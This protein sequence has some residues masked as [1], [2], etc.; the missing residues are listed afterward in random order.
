MPVLE[1]RS[2]L[3]SF[4]RQAGLVVGSYEGRGYGP[5]VR[6][7][8]NNSIMYAPPWAAR[9][10][11]RLRETAHRWQVNS[12]MMPSKMV[13]AVP[14]NMVGNRSVFELCDYILELSIDDRIDRG[15][16]D[17]IYRTGERVAQGRSV[18]GQAC[19]T[20][21]LPID[22]HSP[23]HVGLSLTKAADVL[24]SMMTSIA[25]YMKSV[26]GLSKSP[27]GDVPSCKYR[28][29]NLWVL[30]NV[31][32]IKTPYYEGM[33]TWTHFRRSLRVMRMW[34]N[35]ILASV[36]LLGPTDFAGV[37]ILQ[38]L[39]EFWMDDPNA[40]G[41]WCK[42]AR[43]YLIASL[44][45]D[46]ILG[47]TA[48]ARLSK[49]YDIHKRHQMKSIVSLI[50][51][52]VRDINARVSLSHIYK[53]V[54]HPDC[55]I[56]ECFE[57]TF[58]VRSP[59]IPDLNAIPHV[60]G[61]MRRSIWRAMRQNSHP[62]RIHSGD[63]FLVSESQKTAPD[64]KA[65][66]AIPPS[67]WTSARFTKSPVAEGYMD[68]DVRPVDKAHTRDI[69]I[70]ELVS[71]CN[72]DKGYLTGEAKQKN[73]PQPRENDLIAALRD[74]IRPNSNA[75][76]RAFQK[77]IQKHQAFEEASG[78]SYPE[79]ILSKDLEEFLYNHPE[80]SH[81]VTTE[82]KFGETHKR[83]TRM[84]YVAT[85]KVKLYLSLAERLTKNITKHQIGNSIVS[86][87][88]HRR[89]SL[90][91]MARASV[92]QGDDM[93]SLFISFDMSEFSKKFPMQLVRSFGTIL[94]ELAGDDTL[95][96]LDLA[97]RAAVVAHSSRGL[98]SA[99]AG[100][101]G[102]FEGFLNFIW[103]SIHIA[104]M[105]VALMQAGLSGVVMAYS[106]DGLLY[107]QVSCEDN[108]LNERVTRAVE[109]IQSTY[110]KLGLVFHIHKTLVA[111]T[112]F[113]YLGEIASEG[114]FIPMWVKSLASLG[115]SEDT[116][117]LRPCGAQMSALQGQGASCVEAGLSGRFVE[118]MMFFE[119][120]L[121]M[122]RMVKGIE[123]V[124][125]IAMIISPPSA[126]GFGLRS[127]YSM[128]I[129]SEEQSL[130]VFLAELSFLERTMPAVARTVCN[131]ISSNILRGKR[132]LKKYCMGA[133]LPT[134]MPDTS[135]VS[136][137]ASAAD[138]IA[139]NMGRRRPKNPL[140]STMLNK[141]FHV[142]LKSSG[143]TPRLLSSI[144]SVAPQ[145][146]SYLREQDIT[147]G[148]GAAKLLDKE[149]L[150]HLQ[151]EDSRRVRRAYS[152]WRD[153]SITGGS[154][155]VLMLLRKLEASLK[156]CGLAKP[157]PSILAYAGY[158]TLKGHPG[159]TMRMDRGGEE[160]YRP[161][162]GSVK[163][164][165][166]TSVAY[167]EP[168]R[169]HAPHRSHVK[170]RSEQA[171]DNETPWKILAVYQSACR[172]GS[173]GG[174]VVRCISAALGYD[175]PLIPPDRR[176]NLDRVRA[177][178]TSKSSVFKNI[179][180][181][182]L[183]LSTAMPNRIMENVIRESRGQDMTTPVALSEYLLSLENCLSGILW[184]PPVPG[185]S[186]IHVHFKDG[187]HKSLEPPDPVM[188]EENLHFLNVAQLQPQVI[189]KF[190]QS[191]EADRSLISNAAEILTMGQ[192]G[193]KHR[194]AFGRALANKI[195]KKICSVI[196]MDNEFESLRIFSYRTDIEPLNKAIHGWA[197][198]NAAR[199]YWKRVQR[200]YDN[201][202]AP[203][204]VGK[205]Y[206]Y[207][208]PHA[209]YR[210]AE[211]FYG[212]L[213]ENSSS[214][215]DWVTSHESRV[216]L[217]TEKYTLHC[218]DMA[219]VDSLLKAMGRPICVMSR[220]GN[221]F[222]TQPIITQVR[223]VLSE[224][225]V[226][227]YKLA[228]NA[229]GNEIW[230]QRVRRMGGKLGIGYHRGASIDSVLNALVI[231]KVSLRKS[232]H[233]RQ[234]YNRTTF[235]INY[236]KMR[237][238][239][240]DMYFK[241]MSPDE[242]ESRKDFRSRVRPIVEKAVL[243]ECDL[244][245]I[246]K[247]IALTREPSRKGY[248]HRNLLDLPL[249]H[250]LV[251]RVVT[252][253]L[254]VRRMP[255]GVNMDMIWQ[256]AIQFQ[257]FC[258]NVIMT[259]VSERVKVYP[260]DLSTILSPSSGSPE[261]LAGA[262][263]FVPP[264]KEAFYG[265]II[266]QHAVNANY[267]WLTI[268][269]AHIGKVRTLG[270][271]PRVVVEDDIPN[272]LTPLLVEQDECTRSG[273]S[274]MLR[275]QK[276]RRK[277]MIVLARSYPTPK[278]A[279]DAFSRLHNSGC[280]SASLLYRAIYR[281]Y[282]LLGAIYYG[283]YVDAADEYLE[284]YVFG[285][286]FDLMPVAA[287][288]ATLSDKRCEYLVQSDVHRHALSIAISVGHLCGGKKVR[289]VARSGNL[290]MSVLG[291]DKLSL[292]GAPRVLKGELLITAASELCQGGGTKAQHMWAYCLFEAGLRQLGY[293]FARRRFAELVGIFS[294]RFQSRF[295]MMVR[296][297]VMASATG[298]TSFLRMNPVLRG[299]GDD[300]STFLYEIPPMGDSN[301]LLEVKPNLISVST[302][303]LTLASIQRWRSTISDLVDRQQE[304]DIWDVMQSVSID[305]EE[306]SYA[307]PEGE[308]SDL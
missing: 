132:A 169:A 171:V 159:I 113:E 12:K 260:V 155:T 259:V 142:L 264:V 188:I 117:D 101:G 250:S 272:Q 226:D 82:P 297:G 197:V 72:M 235:C 26:A 255:H 174:S 32:M 153:A 298:I 287:S 80:A 61:V 214:L 38:G 256:D 178:F 70:Q 76:R 53:Y 21:L 175:L 2:S 24:S 181:L 23:M 81:L 77:L 183:A 223:N 45:P 89:S 34:R 192:A 191:V 277:N 268:I 258:H 249:P 143:V 129:V 74:N 176:A 295:L 236:T 93:A 253:L 86:S 14:T 144:V 237:V 194:E 109:S 139:E 199:I 300:D 20:T 292:A 156:S 78:V 130:S 269:C 186:F 28:G 43:N 110:K 274:V 187:F 44:A 180:S 161:G 108:K 216:E 125:C 92:G 31:V 217:T 150:V 212:I 305:D 39:R 9:L 120:Y 52:H 54:P 97:F 22:Q 290:R 140:T 302:Q 57:S 278:H 114:R 222:P 306:R 245:K 219:H 79:E 276:G 7:R 151:G 279:V 270:C 224:T 67:R 208:A 215:P 40:V 209:K 173:S 201:L 18:P 107:A 25:K 234:M 307:L 275:W 29:L 5:K 133:L 293:D 65:M 8:I 13:A 1:L 124:A 213:V 4:L 168:R 84:F 145:M 286:Y 103:T 41:E 299:I 105:E 167:I 55:P 137:M 246:R 98:K 195:A 119:S 205:S 157:A 99:F 33:M 304:V 198:L 189:R 184:K 48:A 71:P 60:E 206:G 106:D 58:P 104:V 56:D 138:L 11:L 190:Y 30:G 59:N 126:G 112:T 152:Y 228:R 244:R 17:E 102:G 10:Y 266:P 147:R 301:M 204:S 177:M 87:S 95:G 96:R 66:S 88:R 232:S 243:K 62:P 69:D 221:Y 47:D 265:K 289:E 288:I 211:N 91:S 118:P 261:T 85:L 283:S 271:L 303:R 146:I 136:T 248:D 121:R 6:K 83:V 122:R 149:D 75:C 196:C 49:A 241:G 185:F 115:V 294:P 281:D 267:D 252:A 210:T 282:V 238:I 218:H 42:A 251:S 202:A 296:R 135:G 111:T 308:W 164:R 128:S 163:P 3:L 127:S 64:Y 154:S 90:R 257:G 230:N 207:R 227:I 148:R 63:D 291:G 233:R 160:G 162:I 94:S 254:Y 220:G 225:I 280:A 263:I 200:V 123:H 170:F 172:Y 27:P 247:H 262:E 165:L 193:E 182:T 203:S 15:D 166:L 284:G 116:R 16:Y 131:V 239:L 51:S 36:S 141:I 285:D 100:C 37:H 134:S 273:V 46:I 242:G 35:Y 229:R 231:A 50:R 68:I 179:P 240:H 19:H 158:G 73:I